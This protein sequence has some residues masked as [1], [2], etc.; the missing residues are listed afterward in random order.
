MDNI[1][2]ES[3]NGNHLCSIIKS[4]SMCKRVCILYTERRF[5]VTCIGL[6]LKD[7]DVE[8]VC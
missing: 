5:F 7:I 1:H 4:R 6:V 3:L 2:V 8:Q